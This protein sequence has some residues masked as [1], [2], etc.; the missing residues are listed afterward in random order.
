MKGPSA[1]SETIM[2]WKRIS[3][4]LP[5]S[6]LKGC[7]S[8]RR[9]PYWATTFSRVLKQIE[10]PTRPEPPMILFIG[11][12][13]WLSDWTPFLHVESILVA[14]LNWR[15]LIPWVNTWKGERLNWS[16]CGQFS[17]LLSWYFLSF[18][19]YGFARQHSISPYQTSHFNGVHVKILSP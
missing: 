7:L 5:S 11:R 2:S 1:I 14:D 12:H 9:R 13:K 18:R 4:P 8:V 17:K 19:R 15:C 16:I 3:L 6:S 10:D